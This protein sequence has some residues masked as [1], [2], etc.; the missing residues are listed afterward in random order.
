MIVVIRMYR[1]GRYGAG[2]KD[3]EFHCPRIDQPIGEFV[4]EI[5]DKYKP[6]E[7]RFEFSPRLPWAK[8]GAA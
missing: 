5:V 6:K 4:Q 7:I 2:S 3:L 1:T 8:D